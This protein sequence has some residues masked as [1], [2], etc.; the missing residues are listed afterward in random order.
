MFYLSMVCALMT[1]AHIGYITD[2]QLAETSED[3]VIGILSAPEAALHQ[4][5]RPGRTLHELHAGDRF[6][7]LDVDALIQAAQ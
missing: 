5:P 7:L 1:L 2:K 4:A 6:D 3:T